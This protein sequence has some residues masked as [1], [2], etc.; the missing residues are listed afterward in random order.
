[1]KDFRHRVRLRVRN[2]HVDWQGVVHNAQYLRYFEIGRI[3]YLKAVGLNLSMESVNSHSRVVVVRNEINYRKSARFNDPI[4]V[5]TR[6]STIGNKS[7]VFNGL[8]VNPESGE[9]IADNA[10]THAWLA[11][12]KDVAVPIKPSFI[13]RV[14]KY[15]KT[16]PAMKARKAR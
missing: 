16:A 12:D 11:S 2:Y 8:I 5:Y 15:E 3:E 6:V 1:M 13:S 7:F 14:R 10:S 4:D 9:I